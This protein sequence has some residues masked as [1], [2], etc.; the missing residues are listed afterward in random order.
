MRQTVE[1]DKAYVGHI[2]SLKNFKKVNFEYEFALTIPK[3]TVAIITCV[4]PFLN[5]SSA[6][7]LVLDVRDE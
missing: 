2:N 6:C 7:V 1:N 3:P 4:S 5:L